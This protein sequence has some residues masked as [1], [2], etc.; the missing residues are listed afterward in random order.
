MTSLRTFQTEIEDIHSREMAKQRS[1]GAR[2]LKEKENKHPQPKKDTH[3]ATEGEPTT[4]ASAPQDEN[5]TEASMREVE[6][7]I[8]VRRRCRR[9]SKAN[10]FSLRRPNSW[11]ARRKNMTRLVIP[12]P[13]SLPNI[14]ASTS[15][16]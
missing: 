3:G 2:Q 16:G 12:L 5:D 15:S 10:F 7:Q 8:M 14:M 6:E 1:Q 4:R 9:G 11:Q 13:P